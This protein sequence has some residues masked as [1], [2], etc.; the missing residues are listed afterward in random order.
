MFLVGDIG[1]TNAR[2]AIARTTD[3]QGIVISDFEKYNAHQF[4]R[5]DDTM[6]EFVDR[7]GLRP[8]LA[9]LAVAGP[10][11]D[12]EVKFTNRTW[13]LNASEIAQSCQL[14]EVR[15]MNDFTAMA[16]SVTRIGDDS[17][18]SLKQGQALENAP[19][20]VAGPG[21]GFGSCLL[22]PPRN[23]DGNGKWQ[24]IA[25]EGGHSLFVP[26][27]ELDRDIMRILSQQSDAISVERIC[28][29]GHLPE[30]VA[31]MAQ[32]HGCATP[33]LAPQEIIEKA[34][35]GDAL[36]RDICQIRA[37][38]IISSLANMAL[39]GG[40]R[41]GIVVA[42][43]VARHLLNFLRAPETI[44][45]FASVWPEGDYLQHIPIRLLVNPLAPLVGAAAHYLQ[46]EK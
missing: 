42:G 44:D 29:G 22:V 41:G 34:E 38:A 31:A 14:D 19:V 37:D 12:G 23:G 21:T 32:L 17:Y 16:Y 6:N 3:D 2:F 30:L 45:R 8:S 11:N 26:R 13:Q 20:L 4:D 39:V 10:I 27:N 24:T 15:L 18:I 46:Y 43:G 35:Q 7:I 25:A 28:G 40:A 5:F 33:D 9:V 1:G 36:C